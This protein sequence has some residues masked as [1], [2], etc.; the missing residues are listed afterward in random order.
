LEFKNSQWQ[1]R[2][3]VQNFNY[4]S[5]YF[6]TTSN[7]VLVSHEY[8]GI[9]KFTIDPKLEKASNIST[10]KNPSKGKNAC[11]TKF[12]N[13]IY[14]A[15][16]E[17]IFK[18]NS[19]KSAFEKDIIFSKIFEKDEYTSGKLIVDKTNKIWVFT[20]NYLHYFTLSKLSSELKKNSIP[21][22]SSLTN[23]MSGFEN[24]TSLSNALYLI[25]T[26]DGYYTIN[27]DELSFKNYS[28]SISKISSNKTNDSQTN[29]TIKEAGVFD[30]DQNNINIYFTVPEYN[31]YINTEYQYLLEDVQDNWSEWSVKTMVNFKNLSPGTYTFKVRAKVANSSPENMAT[32][33]FTIKKPWYRT[34][35]ALLIYLL[36]SIVLGYYINN[37]YKKYYKKQAQKLI[38]ENN[39]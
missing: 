34:N 31:K 21:I 35:L 14:Y 13:T 3:K 12:N 7:Q 1:F 11:L 37:A 8:K 30:Y 28:V 10:L 29:S 20:K 23:S 18:Y 6:E 32:Y 9:F 16:K 24:I 22:P 39:L 4:S 19:E 38:E 26:T 15:Y 5:R 2:N 25:G 33:T 36:L 27:L 17:G